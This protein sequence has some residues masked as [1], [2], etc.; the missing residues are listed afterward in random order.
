[1]KHAREQ[2]YHLFLPERKQV[3]S[4]THFNINPIQL[5]TAESYPLFRPARYPDVAESTR[6][7]DKGGELLSFPHIPPEPEKKKSNSAVE[8]LLLYR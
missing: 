7:V 6:T 4:R 5:T 1:M 8:L 2:S 3:S